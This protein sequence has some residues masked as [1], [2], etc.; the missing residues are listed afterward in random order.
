MSLDSAPH[1]RALLGRFPPRRFERGDTLV[2][3]TL[4]ESFQ[5][6]GA[7]GSLAYI[8]EGLV[9][10]AWNSPFIAPE[11][12]ATTIVAG[13]ARWIGADAFKYGKNLFRYDALA[14]TTA[15]IVPVSYLVDEAPRA[16]LLDALRCVSLD[17]CNAASV[18]GLG[19][20]TLDRR[21]VLLLYNL[22][23]LHPRPEIEIRQQDV[24]EL[25]GVARQTLQ[26]VLKRLEQAGLVSLG[27][28]EICVGEADALLAALRAPTGRLRARGARAEGC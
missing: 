22:F 8:V 9:R 23:R 12:H 5:R 13:D 1:L 20:D 6:P 2:H 24:A 15:S 26:P 19:N 3:N 7:A 16:V 21:A 14:P 4:H 27:Y 28:G 17:W 11:N 25:L 10:G 18:L